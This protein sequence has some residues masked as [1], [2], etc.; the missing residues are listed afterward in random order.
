[1]PANKVFRPQTE[2]GAQVRI[3]PAEDGDAGELGRL[4]TQLTALHHDLDPAR[5]IA[6]TSGTPSA[7]AGFLR[8]QI[9]SPDAVLLV[10]EVGR[11]VVGYVWAGVEGIDY[12]SLRGP[13]GVVY[14]L[15]VEPELRRHGIGRTLLRAAIDGLSRKGVERVVLSA[16]F[17]NEAARDL[18]AAEG[19]RPTMIEMTREIGPDERD[20]ASE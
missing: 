19:F 8:S 9:G 5:F 1:M 11:R 17:R 4:G 15:I 13:A 12:M 2:I 3:R 7:Y 18:F 14:D 16:A 6:T 10:A 20:P